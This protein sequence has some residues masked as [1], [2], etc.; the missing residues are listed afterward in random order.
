M[1]SALAISPCNAPVI[2]VILSLISLKQDVFYG[3]AALFLFSLGYG[4]IFIDYWRVGFFEPV[5]KTGRW[6]YNC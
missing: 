4:L 2:G 6:A 3:A 5:A 1:V